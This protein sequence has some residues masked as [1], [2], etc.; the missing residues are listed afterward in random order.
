M[1]NFDFAVIGGGPAGYSA[2]LEAVKNGLSVI[3]FEE[4][5]IG[6]T[7]LNRGCIPTKFLLDFAKRYSLVSNSSDRG[8]FVKDV[9]IDY[10]K[11]IQE[12]DKLIDKLK[13]N[14]MNYM[15]SN[16]IVIILDPP[17]KGVGI[18]VIDAIKSSKADKIIYVSCKPST[19]ARDVGLIVG[20][21]CHNG[22]EIKKSDNCSS[23]YK[24]ESVRPFDMFAQTKHIETICV[25]ARTDGVYSD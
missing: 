8:L 13:N 25:L 12:K 14:L 22:Q 18:P 24:I 10:N 21:L 4:D 5:R 1:T 19:L 7:C 17:R 15:I 20:T 11:T 16:K 3:L 2:A 6:G 23:D 9:V